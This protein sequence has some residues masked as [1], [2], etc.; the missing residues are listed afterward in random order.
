ML[1]KEMQR[2]IIHLNILKLDKSPYSSP[3]NVIVRNNSI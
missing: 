2:L 3:I 1:G